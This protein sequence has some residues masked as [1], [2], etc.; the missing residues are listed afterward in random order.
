VIGTTTAVRRRDPRVQPP[1]FR[2]PP[3]TAARIAHP[4]TFG[5]EVYRLSAAV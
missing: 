3:S 2:A 4:L 5:E 1:R